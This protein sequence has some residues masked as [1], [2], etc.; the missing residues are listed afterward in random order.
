MNSA[1]LCSGGGTEQKMSQKKVDE[2]KKS[3][4]SREAAS[5]KEVQRRR[6][7]IGILIA[8]IVIGIIWF[9]VAGISNSLG[10]KTTTVELQT[11]A[12]E[13]YVGNIQE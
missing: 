10:S 5:R 12:I 9:A 11:D 13:E 4:A 1:A 3:K 2:Y 6:L 7:E 8:V